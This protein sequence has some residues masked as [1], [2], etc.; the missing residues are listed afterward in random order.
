MK[1]ETIE[2]PIIAKELLASL[3]PKAE[4]EKQVIVHCCFPATFQIGTL[5]RVWKSICLIDETTQH[6]SS[7]IHSE[8]ISIFPYWTMVSPFHDYWF[9]LVF[10]GL[11]KECNTFD[12]KEIIPED[13]GFFVP[14]IPRN[15]SDIYKV[16]LY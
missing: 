14:N 13:G 2:K 4:E 8:N 7:L 15:N 16:K 11:P 9:T 5:I 3:Q 6:K 10:Q 1:M 12:L